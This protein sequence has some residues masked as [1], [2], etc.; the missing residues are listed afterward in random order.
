MTSPSQSALRREGLN[1][2]ALDIHNS[3]PHTE[4]PSLPEIERRLSPRKTIFIIATAC[5]F[6]LLSKLPS[7]AENHKVPTFVWTKR[8]FQKQPQGMC[9]EW[10]F[11]KVS[12]SGCTGRRRLTRRNI[13]C[14]R[15]SSSL[16]EQPDCIFHS[17][18]TDCTN[19]CSYDH[20]GRYHRTTRG[21]WFRCLYINKT[22]QSYRRKYCSA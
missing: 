16:G 13:P 19:R 17:R 4:T 10:T 1:F 22:T 9:E 18:R 6:P 3:Y 14:I 11:G 12:W 8:S 21:K 2:Y 7:H 15:T 5:T 20:S